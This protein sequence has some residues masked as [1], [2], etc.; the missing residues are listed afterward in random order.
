MATGRTPRRSPWRRDEE[1]TETGRHGDEERLPA[2]LASPPSPS[3]LW[4]KSP[5]LPL[6]MPFNPALPLPGSEIASQVLRDQ[7]NG[8]HDE[9]ETIPVGPQGPEGPQGPQGPPFANATV[10]STTTLPPGQPAAVGSTFDG[11]TVHFT[12]AIP[13]GAEG[14]LGPAGSTGPDGPTGPPG[15]PGE[16]TT[17]QLDSAISGTARNP[18]SLSLLDLPISDPPTQAEVQAMVTWLGSFLTALQR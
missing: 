7:F 14:P 12:F 17:A 1:D 16:V 13:Q 18:S 6:A 10:D 2:A 3:L 4:S 9:I 5:R 8:L 11:S 15:P